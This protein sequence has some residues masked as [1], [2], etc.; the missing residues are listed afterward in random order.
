MK[1]RCRDTT[2]QLTWNHRW[3]REDGTR[4][5]GV[6]GT[7]LLLPWAPGDISRTAIWVA[8][9]KWL[10]LDEIAYLKGRENI[11]QALVHPT[12]FLQTLWWGDPTHCSHLQERKK[13]ERGKE[14]ENLYIKWLFLFIP[15]A[16]VWTPRRG[17][18]SSSS[19][20][21][22]LQKTPTQRNASLGSQF[23]S[24]DASFSTLVSVNKQT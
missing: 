14:G 17:I 12:L 13:K 15:L 20:P 24:D 10:S 6:D 4:C 2:S 8:E 19:H 21:G 18:L 23:P 9:M 7:G 16:W 5:L 22:L 11:H 3:Q 1:P